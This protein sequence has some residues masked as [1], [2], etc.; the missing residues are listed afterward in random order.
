M[1]V[2]VTVDPSADQ[3]A[4]KSPPVVDVVDVG[5]WLA[6]AKAV[7]ERADYLPRHRAEGPAV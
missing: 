1:S 5:A 6:S 4:T 3:A 7:R 2:T